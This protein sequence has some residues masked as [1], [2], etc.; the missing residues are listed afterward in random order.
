MA[1][2]T[3]MALE[4]LSNVKHWQ[5]RAEEARVHGG[6]LTDPEAKRMMLEIAASY[7]Q[8]AKRAEERQLANGK[9]SN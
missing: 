4:L 7:D 2:V 1:S 6:Q 3:R 5:H 8:L 9:N